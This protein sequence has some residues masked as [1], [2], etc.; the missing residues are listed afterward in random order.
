MTSWGSSLIGFDDKVASLATDRHLSINV[1]HSQDFMV[2]G[3]D[4]Q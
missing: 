3:P 4:C 1:A 2:S